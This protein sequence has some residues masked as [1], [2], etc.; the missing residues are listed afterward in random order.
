MRLS[1]SPYRPYC[2]HNRE[3]VLNSDSKSQSFRLKTG[4]IIIQKKILKGHEKIDVIAYSIK[5]EDELYVNKINLSTVYKV[6]DG[7][8]GL[9]IT[10]Q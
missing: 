6:N 2:T 1:F 8:V 4:E 7:E 3:P 5:I 9:R 10:L